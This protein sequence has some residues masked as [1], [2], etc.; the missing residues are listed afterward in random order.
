L[1]QLSFSQL[2]VYLKLVVSDGKESSDKKLCGLKLHQAKLS[3]NIHICCCR[4]QNFT[5]QGGVEF[6]I[7]MICGGGTDSE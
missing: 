7:S 3:S 6:D 4:M 1:L 2:E 5:S